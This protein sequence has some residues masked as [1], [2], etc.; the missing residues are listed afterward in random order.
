MIKSLLLNQKHLMQNFL[1][2]MQNVEGDCQSYDYFENFKPLLQFLTLTVEILKN[3]S[4][5]FS[6]FS[7]YYPIIKSFNFNNKNTKLSIEETIK[8]HCIILETFK[9]S[10]FENLR[11][12][13]YFSAIFNV[14]Y[15]KCYIIWLFFC[16]L[17]KFIKFYIFKR[18]LF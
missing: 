3:Y 15:H 1:K 13:K 11:I 9:F 8:N 4:N 7:P 2:N 18:T 12:S 14:K 10:A 5:F 17:F 6:P 16:F